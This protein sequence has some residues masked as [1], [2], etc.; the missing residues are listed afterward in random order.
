LIGVLTN[1]YLQ[2]YTLQEM[3]EQFARKV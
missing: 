3:L 1:L 2:P